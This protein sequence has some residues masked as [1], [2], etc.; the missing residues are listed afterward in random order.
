M[1]NESV[2]LL[3]L[4]KKIRAN[5][6]ESELDLA[7]LV[8]M[9]SNESNALRQPLADAMSGHHAHIDFESVLDDFPPELRGVKPEGAPHTAWQLL[10]H[11][12]IAQWDIL[13]FSRNPNHKSPKWPD[14]YWPKTD[15]PP[16][17]EA[18]RS[19]I[20]AFQ[21]EARE[22]T[23][24]VRDSGRDLLQKFEYGNGQNLLREGLLIA[25]HNSYH[26]GQIVLLKKMLLGDK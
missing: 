3:S 1:L 26:L 10:E 7:R 11:M 17:D 16:N 24:L 22:M 6:C 18:W 21:A 15:G 8:Y 13:E 23:A 2:I 5:D 20:E 25:N 4:N 12:R 9:S 14:G 19:S